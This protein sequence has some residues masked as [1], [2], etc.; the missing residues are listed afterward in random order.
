MPES[1]VTCIFVVRGREAFRKEM[2]HP[3]MDSFIV[4]WEE[5]PP[6]TPGNLVI[7][8]KRKGRFSWDHMDAQRNQ[9]FRM[10]EGYE[11]EIL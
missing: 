6:A 5:L 7:P 9:I 3:G 2:V 11:G 1:P 8:V 10:C 4:E